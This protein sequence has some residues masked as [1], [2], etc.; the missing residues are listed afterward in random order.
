MVM[1][2]KMIVFFIS[3]SIREIAQAL[4]PIGGV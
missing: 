4:I 2:R 1:S 3:P